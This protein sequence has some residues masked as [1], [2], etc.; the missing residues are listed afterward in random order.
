MKSFR[1][2]IDAWPNLQ[3]FADDLRIPYVNAQ[4]MYHRDSITAE[5]WVEVVTAAQR[6]GLNRVTYELLA[7]LKARPTKRIRTRPNKHRSA[8]PDAGRTV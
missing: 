3:A 6:R 7:R 8:S 2:V 5:R 4:V 1:D